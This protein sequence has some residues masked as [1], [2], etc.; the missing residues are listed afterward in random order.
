MI[1]CDRFIRLVRPA[2]F[3]SGISSV[4]HSPVV[5]AGVVPEL[6]S[7]S[8]SV[9]SPPPKALS[10][11]QSTSL[12]PNWLAFGLQM[13]IRRLV[14]P[15]ASMLFAPVNSMPLKSSDE[16]FFASSPATWTSASAEELQSVRHVFTAT[17]VYALLYSEI[18]S[19]SLSVGVGAA[20]VGSVAGGGGAMPSS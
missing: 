19:A 2:K 12:I 6:K 15:D 7:S 3:A 8:C 9:S 10:A 4:T 20:A 16:Y 13:S 14:I 11:P 1:I 17:F 5:S 18:T